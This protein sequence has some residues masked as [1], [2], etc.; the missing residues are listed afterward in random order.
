[1]TWK[2]LLFLLPMLAMGGCPNPAAP[3]GPPAEIPASLTIPRDLSLDTSELQTSSG[4][5]A[6]TLKAETFDSSDVR[7][8]IGESVGLI[9]ES[10]FFLDR[11]LAPI[12]NQDI[13]VD[14][15]VTTFSYAATD[16]SGI[17]VKIDFGRFDLDDDGALE[18]CTGCTCPVGCAPDLAACPS[19]APDEELKPICARVWIAD[20]RFLAAL[21]NRVPTKSNPQSGS[22]RFIVPAAGDLGGSNFAIAYDHAD[23]LDR[24]TATN[25]FFADVDTGSSDFFER[26]ADFVSIVGPEATS[27]K[28]ADLSAQILDEQASTLL[29]QSQY[30]THL[31]FIQLETRADGMF[32]TEGAGGIA[33][34]TP[35]ICAQ[36]S[37]G[38]PVSDILCTDIGLSVTAGEFVDLPDLPDVQFPD[39][40]QFPETPTF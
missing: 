8:S 31:N 21:F 19:E 11:S 40:T 34:I 37:S 32:G 15:T 33:D 10:N 23:P 17:Q 29:F 1:M 6:L 16:G 39:T 5:S 18:A 24:T 22:L 3:P 25:A 9:D 12:S 14:T 30:F 4:A 28:T 35:P 27:K 26:R 2:R 20:T 7:A 13:P 38:N 36:I